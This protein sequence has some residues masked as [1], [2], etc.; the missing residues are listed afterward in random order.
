[1]T[2]D[3]YI[4]NP[5]TFAERLRSK[6]EELSINQSELSSLSGVDQTAISN[7]LNQKRGPSLATTAAIA[8]ALSCDL[9]WLAGIDIEKGTPP[10]GQ[11]W[12][13]MPAHDP[14]RL[15]ASERKDLEKAL[16]VL[17][18]HGVRG[19]PDQALA[20]NIDAFHAAVET[21]GELGL[22]GGAKQ[23]GDRDSSRKSSAGKPRRQSGGGS[24]C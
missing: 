21:A 12:I 20:S 5:S 22:R 4:F 17:R 8:Q 19:A 2:F 3:E 23:Q 15:D 6:M 7:Y 11:D 16:M 9:G 14:R 10:P 18:S 1:M 24:A 13:R